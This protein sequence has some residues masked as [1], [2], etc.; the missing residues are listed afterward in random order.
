ML[1][2]LSPAARDVLQRS[3]VTDM[4]LYLPQEQLPR[5]LY[6]EVDKALRAA[7][8]KWNKQL[9]C[10]VFTRDPQQ[11]LVPYLDT[12]TVPKIQQQLQ[13]FY[14][15]PAVA[16]QV[17]ALAGLDPWMTLLEPSA[18]MGMLALCAAT[19]LPKTQI[20]CIDIDGLACAALRELHNFPHVLEQNFLDWHPDVWFD[21]ILM[22]PP[23][24]KGQDMAHIQYAHQL[25][26]PGGRLVSIVPAATGTRTKTRKHA[27]QAFNQF[28]DQHL[29][30]RIELPGNSF[31]DAG[32]GVATSIL[33]LKK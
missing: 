9:Q 18:G 28:L 8:G 32:T 31:K 24:A 7:G 26:A 27:E 25:L 33:V 16:E 23:F 22:N 20:W 17:I 19:I 5:P 30:N 10:H 21:R 1:M 6:V 14:T 4:R 15:P 11:T 2:P 3:L 13:S 12:T 29:V